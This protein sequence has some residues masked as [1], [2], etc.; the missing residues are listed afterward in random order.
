MSLQVLPQGRSFTFSVGIE[1]HPSFAL[2][3]GEL[4]ELLADGFMALNS[5]GLLFPGV[6][7]IELGKRLFG[8]SVE[9]TGFGRGNAQ[10]DIDRT[11]QAMMGHRGKARR[12]P[13]SED[14]S[15]AIGRLGVAMLRQRMLSARLSALAGR[16]PS[17]DAGTRTNHGGEVELA[18][19]AADSLIDTTDAVLD[20]IFGSSD[21]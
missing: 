16:T 15:D 14:L 12:S 20:P 2:S 10:T 7:N 19:A 9:P 17:P 21:G 4:A 13:Q 3:S 18:L 5:A 8:I 1:L 6:S 11:Y